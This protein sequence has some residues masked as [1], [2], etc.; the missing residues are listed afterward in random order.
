LLGIHIGLRANIAKSDKRIFNE[1]KG[2]DCKKNWLGFGENFYA[3]QQE[4][5]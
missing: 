1:S 3:R 5:L 4:L 2:V